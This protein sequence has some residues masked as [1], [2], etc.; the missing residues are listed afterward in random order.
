MLPFHC[1]KAVPFCFLITQ[2]SIVYVYIL[3]EKYKTF[4]VLIHNRI[5]TTELS[6]LMKLLS[7]LKNGD[8]G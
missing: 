8:Y 6:S 5:K 3:F 1:P 7:I 4:S 2:Y